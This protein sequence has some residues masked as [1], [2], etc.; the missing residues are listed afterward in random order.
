MEGQAATMMITMVGKSAET[1]VKVA[2]KSLDVLAKMAAFLMSLWQK[3]SQKG[4]VNMAKLLKSGGPLSAITMD[5]DNYEK[6]VG[7]SKEQMVPYHAAY[8]ADNDT[9]LVTLKSDD[10][11]RVKTAFEFW[12]ISAT[13]I[14]DNV[15]DAINPVIESKPEAAVDDILQPNEMSI[16]D[17]DRMV[18]QNKNNSDE[19]RMVHDRFWPLIKQADPKRVSVV[20]EAEYEAFKKAAHQEG[21]LFAPCVKNGEILLAYQV[22]DTE[23]TGQLIGRELPYKEMVGDAELQRRQVERERKA[24]TPK[25]ENVDKDEIADFRMDEQDAKEALALKNEVEVNAHETYV[26]EQKDSFDFEARKQ[27]VLKQNDGVD[28]EEWQITAKPGEQPPANLN[29]CLQTDQAVFD[30]IAKSEKTDK[31]NEAKAV[32]DLKTHKIEQIKEKMPKI[33]GKDIGFEK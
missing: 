4:Q 27:E 25:I 3:S 19:M 1:T 28:F 32:R 10:L 5:K 13:K 8:R 2:G 16:S 7:I 24:N 29:L 20:S 26:N 17:F 23:R 12:S 15:H 14:T 6:F 9:Y 31:L 18:E 11:Q 22:K 30:A 33:K 21:I